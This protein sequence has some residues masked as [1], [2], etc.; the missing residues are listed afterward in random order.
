MRNSLIV[1]FVLTTLAIIGCG[2]VNNP[3]LIEKQSADWQVVSELSD[4]DVRYMIKHENVLYLSAVRKSGNKNTGVIYK[5]SDGIKWKK[6][7][8]F[9]WVIGPLAINGDTLYCLGDSLYRYIIPQ[10]KWQTVC[11]PR[12]ISIDPQAAGEMFF[13]KGQLYAMQTMYADAGGVYKVYMDGTTEQIIVYKGYSNFAGS[14]AIFKPFITDGCYVRGMYYKTGIFSFDG[15]TFYPLSEGLTQDE[16][17]YPAANSMAI[18]NDTL[19]AGFKNPGS[20]KFLDS[21]TNVWVSYTDTLPYSPTAFNYSPLVKTEPTA[22]TFI[23]E[24]M[25]VSTH[26]LG[27][28]E[29]KKGSGW[30]QMATGLIQTNQMEGFYQ[31]IAFLES[32]GTVL[33]AAYGEP[34]YAWWGGGMGV[35]RYN[36]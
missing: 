4:L 31:P 20:I 22:I 11:K 10:M 7:R 14:K 33:I 6:V 3:A 15:S 12:P 34:G 29:W 5:T 17:K 28:L 1:L 35:Y 8:E 21:R 25:F 26:C 19:F 32:I 24:R 18:H 2:N 27:V 16:W 13:L 30:K 36:L 23:G 9:G